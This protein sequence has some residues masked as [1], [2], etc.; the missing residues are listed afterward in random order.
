MSKRKLSHQQKWRLSKIQQER[1]RRAQKKAEA[2]ENQL[3]ESAASDEKQGRVIA[4]FGARLLVEVE[5][6]KIISCQSRAN[7]GQVVVGDYVIYQ[8]LLNSEDGVVTA[9]CDRQSILA[10][11]LYHGEVKAIA[12]NVDQIF[13]LNSPI[14]Q[15]QTALIDRY[16]IATE[17]THIEAI[18]VFNKIDLLDAE[19]RARIDQLVELYTALGYRTLLYS[20]KTDLGVAELHNALHDKTS[21]LVGQS[22]VGK[23][24]TIKRLLP[25]MDIQIG[26][27]N[28]YGTLGRHTT[29]VARLY[30]LPHGG[31]I[32]DSPGV[33]DFG[34]WHLPK[35]DIING[36]RELRELSGMCQ[37]RNCSHAHEP[38]C[39]ILQAR[40]DGN[41]SEERFANF[42]AIM[43]SIE[44][45]ARED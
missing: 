4:N 2:V 10:R 3:E 11:T 16:L 44:D 17:M 41:I 30:H 35:D 27:L 45:G 20:N 8:Q 34:L 22:G 38:G 9:I 26:E 40:D 39:A 12:A 33:R 28:E 37:F 14:P 19:T 36:F 18:V 29:S 5:Q 7:L 42:Q 23:S 24:S 13:I 43:S 21:V 1:I 25:D 32:I 15:L 6:H 31:D